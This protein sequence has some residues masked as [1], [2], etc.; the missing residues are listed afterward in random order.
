MLCAECVTQD[1]K[2]DTQ[3]SDEKFGAIYS[4]AKLLAKSF[5]VVEAVKNVTK[6]QRKRVN[7]Q[8]LLTTITG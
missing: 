4:E 5:G 1:L 7:K 6:I 3:N 2:E 8:T